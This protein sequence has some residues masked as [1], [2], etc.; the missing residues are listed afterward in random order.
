MTTGNNTVIN[1]RSSLGTFQNL[2][3]SDVED[4]VCEN[5][6]EVGDLPGKLS[7]GLDRDTPKVTLAVDESDVS[8]PLVSYSN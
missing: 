6:T 7:L 3:G 1:C 8:I 5:L 2:F 4:E